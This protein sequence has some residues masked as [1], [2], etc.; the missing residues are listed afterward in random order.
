MRFVKVA[1]IPIIYVV[2]RM[3]LMR[4]AIAIYQRLLLKAEDEREVRRLIRLC[5]Q[6]GT[7][8]TFRAAG[9]SLSGQCSSED[10]LIV[11]NDGFKRKWK[12]STMEKP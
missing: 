6:C 7:P 12:L 4:L 3:V 10:V 11:C 9:S 1:Y 8:F 5:Q 2:M